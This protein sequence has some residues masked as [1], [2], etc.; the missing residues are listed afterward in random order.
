MNNGFELPD[1]RLSRAIA[2]RQHALGGWMEPIYCVNC[3]CRYGMITREWAAHVFA[4]CNRCAE[5][6][7][8][9]PVPPLPEGF[10]RPASP[11]TVALSGATRIE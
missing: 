2:E 3:G 10:G 7:G 4:L 6:H 11:S 5:T 9:M 8:A 1:A